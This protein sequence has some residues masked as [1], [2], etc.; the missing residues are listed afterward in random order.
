MELLEKEPDNTDNDLADS[1]HKEWFGEVAEE[2][3]ELLG[4]FEGD[5]YENV[6]ESLEEITDGIKE[7]KKHKHLPTGE[8]AKEL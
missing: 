4:F 7:L 5:Q 3:N 1:K 6:R 8:A 2:V